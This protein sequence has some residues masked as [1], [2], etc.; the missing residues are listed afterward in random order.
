MRNELEG[1]HI[2]VLGL[3]KSG[4]AAAKL[5]NRMGASV[6]VNDRNSLAGDDAAAELQS[7]GIRV[8]VGGH[9]P[10]LLDEN[11]DYIVKNPGIPYSIPFLQLAIEKSVPI[12][13]EVE[14]SAR[15]T[16]SPFVAI[17]GSNGKTTTTTLI[18]RM[19][20]EAGKNPKLAG[21]IG[22]VSCEV[23]EQADGK[24]PIVIEL[25]SFQLLGIETFRPKVAVLL[26]LFDAHLD[27]HGTRE[28]YGAAKARI[29]MNQTEEDFAVVNYDDAEVVDLA[30]GTN[31]KTVYFSVE[32]QI[33]EGAC[34]R[35][36]FLHVDGAKIISLE[37]IVL[38][39]R[40]NLQNILAAAAAAKIMGADDDAIR[41][42]LTTFTG[43][44]HRLQ[45]VTELNGRKI[46]NDS[47]ATNTLATT[48]A[49]SAFQQP[50]ILLAGGLDRGNGF[51][52]LIP[53]MDR[54]KA[55][56]AF[57][58]TAEKIKGSA[59]KAGIKQIKL[60]DNVE[61]AVP[62]AYELSNSGDVILLSPACASWDQFKTFEERGDMFVKSVHKLK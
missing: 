28:E 19:L 44:E 20:Q 32:Q 41:T 17:T 30:R 15:I 24:Q 10:E 13:T 42:V 16:S 45:F 6:T 35:E 29:F 7:L 34:V 60:V 8:I 25:S 31:A 9:P 11:V 50:V 26:N 57:G 39:G 21:N 36:G 47:K 40:H 43:V 38:P 56:V 62:A 27:Y 4:L 12:I 23:A 33:D 22:T 61:Q 55:V 3:A 18:H 46:Y 5:L 49:L 59:E 37:D 1:K 53:Y 54:V 58:Q 51:D 14:L 48:A 52:E 2:L